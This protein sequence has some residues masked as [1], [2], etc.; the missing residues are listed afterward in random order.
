MIPAAIPNALEA[1]HDQNPSA[2]VWDA[3]MGIVNATD[4]SLQPELVEM[5]ARETR[6]VS[7]IA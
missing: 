4:A 5:L 3:L 7:W 2:V 1:L 6:L